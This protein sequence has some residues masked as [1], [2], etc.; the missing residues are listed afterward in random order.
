MGF[1]AT[2]TTSR[3][4]WEASGGQP[5]SAGD[6]QG[7]GCVDDSQRRLMK[8]TPDTK[9]ARVCGHYGAQREE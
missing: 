5:E 2:P 1:D 6:A 7:G 4:G 8:A 9:N 3:D